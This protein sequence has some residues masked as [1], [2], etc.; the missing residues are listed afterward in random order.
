VIMSHPGVK[1]VAVIGVPHPKWGETVRAIVVPHS[2]ESLSAKDVIGLCT[3]KLDS[4]KKPTSVIF[5]D[6]L[7]RGVNGGKVQKRVLREKYGKQTVLL[8]NKEVR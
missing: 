3:K 6:A 1:E 5:I 2:D 7:P 8:K 4:H